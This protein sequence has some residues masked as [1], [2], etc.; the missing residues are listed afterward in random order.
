MEF[1]KTKTNLSQWP[2]ETKLKGAT[3]KSRSEP[4]VNRG[5]FSEDYVKTRQFTPKNL[6]AKAWRYLYIEILNVSS[7]DHYLFSID[8]K[9]VCRYLVLFIMS[10][11]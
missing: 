1:R 11:L 7:L 10:S 9:A 2:S 6:I 4:K 8:V 3:T 5:R